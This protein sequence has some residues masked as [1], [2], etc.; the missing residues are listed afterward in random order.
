MIAAVRAQATIARVI[1][2]PAKIA[3][4]GLFNLNAR[5]ANITALSASWRQLNAV[6]QGPAQVYT[7]PAIAVRHLALGVSGGRIG[8]DGTLSPQLNATLNVQNLPAS[9]AR[10]FA[11]SIDASGTLSATAQVSGSRT[12]PKGHITLDARGIKLHSGPAAALPAA[13][14]SGTATATGSSATIQTKLSA[15]P[16]IALTASG[17]VP[18]NASGPVNLHVTGHTDLRFALTRFPATG[19]ICCRAACVRA[20]VTV[21]GNASAPRANGNLTLE[22]GSVENIASGLNLTKISARVQASGP[23]IDLQSFQATAGKGSITGHGSADLA[24]TDIPID[25]A[26]DAANATPV[27]SDIV[28]EVLDAALTVKGALKGKMALGRHQ[29]KSKGQHQYSGNRCCP[30]VA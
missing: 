17:L 21:T 1:S 11:P 3:L 5:S 24:G 29:I 23:R 8:L 20:D 16:N 30:E 4:A 19:E 15:G 14:F 6:L 10:M 2:A 18:L 26:I 27:S 28:T 13:D 22:N 7:Q 25:F 12:A 9:L